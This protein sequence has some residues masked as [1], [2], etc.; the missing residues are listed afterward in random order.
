M[1]E[2]DWSGLFH[3]TGSAADTPRRLAALLGDDPRALVEGCM[4]LWSTLRREGGAWPATAPT[5]LLVVDLLDDPRLG[6]DDPSLRDAMLVYLYGVGVAADVGGREREVRARIAGRGPELDAWTADYLAADQDGRSRM[7]QDEGGTGPG[8]LVIERAALACGDLAPGLLR[9]VLP[10]LESEHG[11]RRAL[12]AAAVGSL[13]LDASGT[14]QCP[15]LVERLA[16]VARAAS[17]DPYDLAT[18]LLAVGRLGGDTRPWL[19]DPHLGVRVCAAMAPGLAGEAAAER[20]LA[21]S[22]RAFVESF[23]DMAPP[24]QFQSGPYGDLLTARSFRRVG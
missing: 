5:A 1:T 21:V 22:P 10:Y 2:V 18:V 11:R 12:A 3:A 19:T 6:P 14:G 17:G 24:P 13:A 16:G 7:W 15:L 20:E 9:R 4:E 23:G 8:E